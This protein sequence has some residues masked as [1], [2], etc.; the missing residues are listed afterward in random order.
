MANRVSLEEGLLAIDQLRQVQSNG[1]EEDMLSLHIAK[2]I[3]QEDVQENGQEDDPGATGGDDRPPTDQ[4]GEVE[5]SPDETDELETKEGEAALE[6]LNECYTSPAMEG[7]GESIINA[8]GHIG[9]AVLNVTGTVGKVALGF[10]WEVGIKQIA[11]KVLKGTV[12]LLDLTAKVLVKGSRTL[13]KYYNNYH[14]SFEKLNERLAKINENISNLPEGDQNIIYYL[15]DQKL[16]NKLKI[17]DSFS[18]VEHTDTL[19][20]FTDTFYSGLSGVARTHLKN[21][22]LVMDEVGKLNAKLPESLGGFDIKGFK[23]NT[24]HNYAS[25]ISSLDTY[26]SNVTLPGDFN[27][28]AHLPKRD[29][30]RNTLVVALKESAVFFGVAEQ[31]S[32]KTVDRIEYMDA[33]QL[34]SLVDKTQQLCQLVIKHRPIFESLLKER[35]S[36]LLGFKPYATFIT[37][38]NDYLRITDTRVDYILGELRYIDTVYFGTMIKL[39]DYLVRY[40]NHI[41][42]YT[43]RNTKALV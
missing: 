15:D 31:L 38:K 13:V 23:T 33:S 8:T 28:V 39:N 32:G 6:S 37:S 10:L 25:P 11:P 43:N 1:N 24:N 4:T 19:I 12:R 20:K 21:V 22:N 41:V 5:D 2:T 36:L 42:T 35:Q 14:N 27:I 40:I 29:L 26:V 16:I 30:Q 3:E 17:G 7:I 18:L 34:A 9:S